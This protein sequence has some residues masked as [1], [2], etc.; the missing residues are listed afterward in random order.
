[1]PT[2]RVAVRIRETE[3][4]QEVS[5]YGNEVH[6]VVDDA[7]EAIPR[8]REHLES[9]RLALDDARAIQPS[10]EDVFVRL[11]RRT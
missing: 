4:A 7:A 11:T 9:S 1:M 2:E 5:I 6:A 10:I 3:L 8:I